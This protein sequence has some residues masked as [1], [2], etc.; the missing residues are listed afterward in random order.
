MVP[1][2][3]QRERFRCFHGVITLSFLS[4]SLALS[5]SF[6][7]GGGSRGKTSE[8]LFII[9]LR[10][11]KKSS[12]LT[13]RRGTICRATKRTTSSLLDV[14]QKRLVLF[15]LLVNEKN[16]TNSSSFVSLEILVEKKTKA[17]LLLIGIL[18]E[19]QRN[20]CGTIITYR[21]F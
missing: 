12:S 3:C 15:S 5:L 14:E 21:T 2:V 20:P 6:L 11:E 19:E 7:C 18:L 1:N 10:K 17:L 16:A 9:N 8:Y 13:R 4:F